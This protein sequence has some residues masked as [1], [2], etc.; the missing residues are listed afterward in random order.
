M[1]ERWPTQKQ[2]LSKKEQQF[3]MYVQ[4]KTKRIPKKGEETLE[5]DRP[6]ILSA[7]NLI[8]VQCARPFDFFPTDLTVC[9]AFGFP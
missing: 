9:E 8:L 1:L 3:H 6:L 2:I 4:L 7:Q 5:N